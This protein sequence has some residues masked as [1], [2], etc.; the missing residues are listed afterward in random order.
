MKFDIS[1]TIKKERIRGRTKTFR[2]QNVRVI[3][4]TFLFLFPYETRLDNADMKIAKK[5]NGV[6]TQRWKMFSPLQSLPSLVSLKVFNNSN[7]TRICRGIRMEMRKRCTDDDRPARNSFHSFIC[8][9]EQC[10]WNISRRRK[11][12]IFLLTISLNEILNLWL[13]F[14]SNN[15]LFNNFNI[16]SMLELQLWYYYYFYVS[17]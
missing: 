13:V 8:S 7:D 1:R 3:L 11:K 15:N 17:L 4:C 9:F 12:Q 2:H 5:D 16:L 14:F 6:F 10:Y